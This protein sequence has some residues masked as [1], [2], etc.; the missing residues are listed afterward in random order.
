MCFFEPETEWFTLELAIVEELNQKIKQLNSEREIEK[1][2]YEKQIQI[3]QEN[4][5]TVENSLEKA[6]Q[7]NR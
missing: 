4:L 7:Q 6:Q 5:K 3:L 1:L 2:K